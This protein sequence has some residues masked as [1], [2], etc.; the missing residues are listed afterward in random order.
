[1][2]VNLSKSKP[3]SGTKQNQMQKYKIFNILLSYTNLFHKI[4][5]F[6]SNPSQ[7]ESLVPINS[8]KLLKKFE[9]NKNFQMKK[10]LFKTKTT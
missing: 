4:K 9:K 6:F 10:L 5:Q 2:K 8:Q 7:K 3:N 1:M